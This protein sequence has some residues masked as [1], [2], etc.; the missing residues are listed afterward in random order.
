MGQESRDKT[1]KNS[2]LK[3]R[4]KITDGNKVWTKKVI[5]RDYTHRTSSAGTHMRCRA[6]VEGA[7]HLG[8][9]RRLGFIE[10]AF[11]H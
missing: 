8:A 11:W 4:T 1:A 7:A 5:D 6:G 9:R 2:N 3:E 10:E